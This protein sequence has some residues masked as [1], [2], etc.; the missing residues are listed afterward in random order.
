MS[1]AELIAALAEGNAARLQTI[2]G[3][4][5]RTAERLTVDLQDRARKLATTAPEAPRSE[6]TRD[7]VI[8]ALVNL[9]YPAG[10]AERGA[11]AALA[12][13]GEETPFEDLLRSALRSLH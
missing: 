5:K 9:G 10:Q 12:D 3:V 8:S 13:G 6:T 11:A 2:P 4:G 1:A 7:D